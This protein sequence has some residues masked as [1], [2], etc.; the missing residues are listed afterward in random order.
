MPHRIVKHL[1]FSLSLLLLSARRVSSFRVFSDHNSLLPMAY[2]NYDDC[3]RH[4]FHPA[5]KRRKTINNSAATPCLPPPSVPLLWA[6][7][8]DQEGDSN[9][10]IPS[11]ERIVN[12]IQQF[13]SLAEDIF[14]Q[15]RAELY[16][17][18]DSLQAMILATDA[19]KSPLLHHHEDDTSSSNMDITNGHNEPFAADS[20]SISPPSQDEK[21]NSGDEEE[22]DKDVD[23]FG[24]AAPEQIQVD[25]CIVGGGPAGCTCALYTAR[26]GLKTVIL[27][28]NAA[29]GA[30]AITS[31]I[32]NYPGVGEKKLFGEEQLSGEALLARI[33]QQAMD[34]GADYRRAQVF[35]IDGMEQDNEK[36]TK[37][38]EFTVYTPDAIFKTR[39]LVLAT[40]AMGRVSP[41]FPGEDTYLGMG[42]SY[43]ATCDGA[44]YQDADV[45]VKGISLEAMEEATFLTKYAKTVHWVTPSKPRRENSHHV[46]NLL[47][48]GNVKKWPLT[49]FLSVEGDSVKGVTGIKVQQKSKDEPEIIPVEGVFIYAGG[50]G[51]SKPITD[52]VTRNTIEYKENGGVI[53][54]EGM[55]T[56]VKGVFA[57]GDIRNTSHKQVVVAA[58]DGCIAAMSIDKY[59]NRHKNIR[60]DWIH[61]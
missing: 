39:A 40:G 20:S 52:F 46:Q 16:S 8:N 17:I 56:N 18:Q 43:C 58:S 19:Q 59:L 57:I 24:M 61:K 44:F 27:D 22:E 53:V 12:K 15:Q 42:V 37:E 9:T 28:K 21:D 49:K 36:E 11:T 60:V 31:H 48:K 30:L 51:G 6:H 47:A 50:G 7:Q 25:V 1:W 2:R 35:M 34:Y 41:P 26:A 45:A 4:Y 29:V 32:A 10:S 23:S 54:N 55:E 33:R 38:P 13:D 3:R 14:D 5:N